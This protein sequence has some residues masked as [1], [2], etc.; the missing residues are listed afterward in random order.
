MN[1]RALPLW[2]PSDWNFDPRPR[3]Q[4]S[5]L[6]VTT[7]LIRRT[8]PNQERRANSQQT[9]SHDNNPPRHEGAKIRNLA[10]RAR[11]AAAGHRMADRKEH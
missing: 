10:E 5:Q 4:G 11:P 6:S 8:L 3:H 7:D 2:I 1:A 9:A